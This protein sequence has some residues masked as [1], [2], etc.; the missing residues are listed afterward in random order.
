MIVEEDKSILSC[1]YCGSKEFINE[2]DE[3][4]IEKM[5]KEIELKKMEFEEREQERKY[6][7]K[8]KDRKDDIVS[9]IASFLFMIFAIGLLIVV[10]K[11]MSSDDKETSSAD[12]STAV[13]SIMS[14]PF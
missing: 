14:S 13:V 7:E 9:T 3:V 4:K 2:S 1:P 6:K 11:F 8:E 10:T 12:T 5:K